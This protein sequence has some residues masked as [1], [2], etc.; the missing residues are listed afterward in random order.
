MSITTLS[1]YIPHTPNFSS[2]STNDITQVSLSPNSTIIL[3]SL[4]KWTIREFEIIQKEIKNDNGKIWSIKI[5]KDET[6]HI[7]S[8]C[9]DSIRHDLLSKYDHVYYYVT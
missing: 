3:K 1:Q 7:I 8:R 2:F 6:Y 4:P 9:T 5:E